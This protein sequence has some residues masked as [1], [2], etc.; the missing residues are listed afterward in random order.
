M[1]LGEKL[2]A[3]REARGWSQH[4]AAHARRVVFRLLRS[5]TWDASGSLWSLL[6]EPPRTLHLQPPWRWCLGIPGPPWL[7]LWGMA[8]ALSPMDASLLA[9][10]HQRAQQQ[11]P[12]FERHPIPAADDKPTHR[13]FPQPLH[14]PSPQELRGLGKGLW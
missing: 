12:G 9:R 3:L 13:P 8:R 1:T 2:K 5:P 7:R 4:E 6:A 10:P 11:T 14:T